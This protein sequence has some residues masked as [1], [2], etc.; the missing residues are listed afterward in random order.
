MVHK[1]VSEIEGLLKSTFDPLSNYLGESSR[2]AGKV[3]AAVSKKE[4]LSNLKQDI[5]SAVFEILNENSK[6]EDELAKMKQ[7]TEEFK[8]L[9]KEKM[10]SAKTVKP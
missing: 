10:A 7:K 2:V 3:K 5:N 8:K 1:K 6:L 9:A 4:N